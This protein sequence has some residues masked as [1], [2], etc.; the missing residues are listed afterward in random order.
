MLKF[1]KLTWLFL[2]N[3]HDLSDFWLGNIHEISWN[4]VNHD[5]CTVDNLYIL[6]M[7]AYAYGVRLVDDTVWLGILLHEKG[8][9]VYPVMSVFPNQ[10]GPFSILIVPNRHRKHPP[11]PPYWSVPLIYYAEGTC[12]MYLLREVRRWNWSLVANVTAVK[13]I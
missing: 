10:K 9:L 12:L 8:G 6:H 2:V 4:F 3:R 7:P 5:S 13:R 1:N 11:P